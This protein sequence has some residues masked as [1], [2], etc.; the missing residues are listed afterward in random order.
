M[1]FS[2]LKA[3]YNS[4]SM[5]DTILFNN[6]EIII[7]GKPFLNKEWLLNWLLSLFKDCSWFF[8]YS[9]TTPTKAT[10]TNN[11]QIVQ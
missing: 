9:V 1:Y 3:L 2:E 10:Q 11:L 6:K 8:L 7:G 4:D 5:R